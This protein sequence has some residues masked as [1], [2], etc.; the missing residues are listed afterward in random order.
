[1]LIIALMIH[2]ERDE[3]QVIISDDNFLNALI[4]L[5]VDKDNDG[6]ISTAEA[7]TVVSLNAYNN[8]ISDLTGIELFI[9][10]D[11]LDCG[12][13]QLTELNV[14]KN[15]RMTFLKCEENNLTTLDLSN[16]VRLKTLRCYSNSLK[17]LN[18]SN[19]TSLITLNCSDNLLT[20]LDVSN[21]MSLGNCWCS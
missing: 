19:I 15:T 10:L 13:N 8:S 16:N 4:E 18:L 7:E 11:S 21:N 6:Q 5:G 17:T 12:L 9:N 14:T 2:C 20:N 3:I 1:M